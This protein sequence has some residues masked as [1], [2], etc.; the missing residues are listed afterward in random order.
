MKLT[1]PYSK[2]HDIFVQDKNHPMSRRRRF[3]GSACVIF[4]H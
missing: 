4:S 1:S 3:N 2:T